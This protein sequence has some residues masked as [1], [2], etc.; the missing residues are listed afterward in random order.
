MIQ[1]LAVQ[2]KVVLWF[3][4][5]NYCLL[6]TGSIDQTTDIPIVAKSFVVDEYFAAVTL[7]LE[8]LLTL[9]LFVAMMY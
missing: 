6:P 5:F 3:D 2:E 7:N 8:N 1:E 4:W 9:F